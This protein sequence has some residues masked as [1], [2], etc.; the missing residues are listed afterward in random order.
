M[1][2]HL[3]AM[4]ET[5]VRSLDRKDLLLQGIAIAFSDPSHYLV[6]KPIELELLPLLTGKCHGWRGLVGYSP[7]G[8]K[9]SYT[10][11]RLWFL[12]LSVVV[13]L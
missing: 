2:K 4:W 13:Y 12:S 8:C 3:P 9:E 11:E 6:S 10:T 1:I 5:Q 7:W